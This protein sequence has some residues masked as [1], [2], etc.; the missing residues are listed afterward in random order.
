MLKFNDFKMI[1]VIL[2][3]KSSM[4]YFTYAKILVRTF[5][6]LNVQIYSTNCIGYSNWYLFHKQKASDD[7][8]AYHSKTHHVSF[9]CSPRSHYSYQDCCCP[10]LWK[11]LDFHPCSKQNVP[12]SLDRFHQSILYNPKYC[13]HLGDNICTLLFMIDFFKYNEMIIYIKYQ[14]RW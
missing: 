8:T 6:L 14:L 13:S 4:H 5:L 12:H 9:L 11:L 1:A 3:K 2:S 10:N 7:H